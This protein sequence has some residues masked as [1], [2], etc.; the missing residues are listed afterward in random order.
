M[1]VEPER[2]RPYRN[3]GFSNET[4]TTVREHDGFEERDMLIDGVTLRATIRDQDGWEEFQGRVRTM[5]GPRNILS[6]KAYLEAGTKFA[7]TIE[8]LKTD[9]VTEDDLKILLTHAGKF[10]GFGSA[11]SREAGKFKMTRFDVV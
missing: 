11:R 8:F 10:V 4:K 2:I 9:K 6:R 1:V 5:Q 3:T 7:F